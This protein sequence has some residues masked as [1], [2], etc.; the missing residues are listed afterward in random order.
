[1]SNRS[2]D[3]LAFAQP[4][5]G[6]ALTLDS[7]R[8]VAGLQPMLASA[9]GSEVEVV[10]VVDPDA[11][12]VKVD[13]V[14]IEQALMHLS[15]NG[16]E[17]M[18]KRGRLTLRAARADL[19]EQERQRLEAGTL[20]RDR[21]AGDF[22]LITVTDTGRGMTPDQIS[23][24]FEPFYTTKKD[25]ANAGLGLSSVYN[26]IALHNGYI[27]VQSQPGCGTTFLI[28]LPVCAPTDPRDI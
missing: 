21:H 9:L 22:A 16:A 18:S 4:E 3:L 14:R 2:C 26:I 23:H 19:S 15:V 28:Y 10:V 5:S 27:D 13:P 12:Q 25:R 24:I 11:G 8:L 20:L 1:M 7:G 17:A 6:N